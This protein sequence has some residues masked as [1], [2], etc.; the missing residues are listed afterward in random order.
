[1][2]S[3]ELFPQP[4]GELELQALRNKEPPQPRGP[5]LLTLQALQELDLT[6]CSKLSD[7]SLAKVGLGCGQAGAGVGWGG[8]SQGPGPT[9]CGLGKFFS[10]A[11]TACDHSS[12]W[13]WGTWKGPGP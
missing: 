1:M 8:E 2:R 7:A 11:S 6:A 4:H 5:S 13:G 3:R 10:L 9:H 12:G